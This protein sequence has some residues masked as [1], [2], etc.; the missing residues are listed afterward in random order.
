MADTIEPTFET[1]RYRR[2]KQKSRLDLMDIDSELEELS[3]LVQEASEYA[4]KA[5]EIREQ[6]KD[7]LEISEAEIA[8]ALRQEPQANGKPPSES[9]VESKIPLSNVYIIKKA[10]LSRARLDAALWQSQVDALR[11]KSS[12]IRAAADL[13]TSGY[14]T[15]NYITDKRRKEL[16]K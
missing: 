7:N 2:L 1:E 16:R 12:S 15:T 8:D 9:M 4:A 5:N 6:A 10:E 13:I 14:M 11:T 3:F